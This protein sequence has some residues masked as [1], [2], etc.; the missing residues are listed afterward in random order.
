MTEDFKK[1]ATESG[2]TQRQQVGAAIIALK[3]TVRIT[4]STIEKQ[5]A[6]LMLEQLGETI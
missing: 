5:H 4:T 1:T 3:T 6:L 2:S